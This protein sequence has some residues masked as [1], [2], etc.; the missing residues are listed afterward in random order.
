MWEWYLVYCEGGFLERA[1]HDVQL[2]LAKP[3]DRRAPLLATA[4]ERR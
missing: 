4:V 3:L 2:L 1:I